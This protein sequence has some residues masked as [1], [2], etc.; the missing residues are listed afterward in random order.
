[1]KTYT[2]YI[3]IGGNIGNRF[4]N[5][6]TAKELIKKNCGAIINESSIYQT[7]A[8]GLTEQPDFLNQVLMLTTTL[9][10]EILMQ[11][12][13]S[14]EESMGRKRIIKFGPRIID[15]DILLIDDLIIETE[16]L[17]VPHPA[18]PQRK[19]AL[20]P[21][22]EVA[23]ELQYPVEKKFIH[24]LLADCKDELVVQKISASAS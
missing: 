23:P 20:V 8:W 12:L 21:L 4:A 10:P 14:I 5:L 18:L 3:L 9:E 15:L 7:A 6:A 24:Q 22:N 11:K 1:M 13:L 2:A 16:L 19:F 17:S